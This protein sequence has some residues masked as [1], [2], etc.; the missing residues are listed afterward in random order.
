MAAETTSAPFSIR[1]RIREAE[2]AARNLIVRAAYIE[3]RAERARADSAERLE[4]NARARELRE[5]AEVLRAE[6]SELSHDVSRR[7]AA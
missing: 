6:I 7:S 4:L 3:K 2:Q 5:A 1:A